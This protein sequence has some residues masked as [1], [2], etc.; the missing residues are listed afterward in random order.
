MTGANTETAGSP[1]AAAVDHLTKEADMDE[2][3]VA[4]KDTDAEYTAER[5]VDLR[6]QRLRRPSP[7]D[8]ED[9]HLEAPAGSDLDGTSAPNDPYGV[10][11]ANLSATPPSVHDLAAAREVRLSMLLRPAPGAETDPA[12]WGWRGKLNT[13]G[14]QLKP[15]RSGPEVAYRRAVERIRQPLPGT[16]VVAIANPKGGSGV[17]P[18]TVVLS[19]LFGRLRGG[20]VVAWDANESCGTLGAR[21]AVCSGPETVWDVLAHAR[22]LCSVNG[23][24]SA[25]GR[26][27]QRQPSLD[28]VL[29]SDQTP[30]GSVNVGREE[31]AAVLAV[32]RRHRSMILIDTGNNERAPAFRWTVENATQLVV[33]VVCRRDVVVAALRLL[34]GIADAGHETLAANAIIV[35]AEH[36]GTRRQSEVTDALERAGVTRVLHVPYDPALA[37]GERI[38][39]SRM[40]RPAL[41]AWAQVAA[42]VADSVAETLAAQYMPLETEFIPQSRRIGDGLGSSTPR[43]LLAYALHEGTGSRTGRYQVPAWAD[44]N[45]EQRLDW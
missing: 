42:V 20:Q 27:L 2:A 28:E 37:G 32:L 38:V 21:A 6:R 3:S 34:D 23:D 16:P 41:R 39:V 4:T 45:V 11:E 7:T 43:R 19:A 40:R 17:T 18:T 29:A 31:C 15:A 33:P 12:Q 13:V 8:N 35:L 5:P 10:G 44:R 36:G 1:H 24:A 30:G 22:E 26:M 9:D 25:L 14:L